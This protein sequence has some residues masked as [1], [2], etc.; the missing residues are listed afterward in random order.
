[1]VGI[2]RA[3]VFGLGLLL[4]LTAEAAAQTTTVFPREVVRPEV[5]DFDRPEAGPA[6]AVP[7]EEE[8][9]VASGPSFVLDGVR[10]TGAS[11]YDE[12]ELQAVA[13]PWIGQPAQFS[14]LRALADAVEA[15]YRQDGYLATRAIIAAQE[16]E[17]GVLD[18]RIVEGVIEAIALRGELGRAEPKVRDL[19]APLVGLKPLRWTE[20]ERRLLLAR[21]LPG[22]SLLASLRAAG[23][24]TEGGLVL[25]VD[26]GHDPWDAFLSA[27]NYSAE[28][29]GEWIV[30]GGAAA[31]SLLL[32]GDRLE[33][34][35]LVTPELGE[36][37]LALVT[38]E[39]PLF[40]DGLTFELSASATFSEPGGVLE[41]LDISYEAWTARAMAEYALLRTREWSAWVSAGL[42]ATWQDSGSD[43]GPGLDIDEE[44][45]VAFLGGRLVTREILG[46]VTDARIELRA[47]LDALGASEKGDAEL[48]PAGSDPQFQSARA[49]VRYD[50]L[51][52][53]D[54]SLTGK[55]AGQIGSE[56]LP[57]LELFSLG[58]YTIGRGFDPGAATGDSGVAGSLELGHR[59][60]LP[61]E[62]RVSE[63]EIFGFVEGGHVWRSGEED[64]LASVGLGARARLF[65]QVDVEATVAVPLADPEFSDDDDVRLLFR[66][67]SLF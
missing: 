8:A 61:F 63:P 46:G 66:A 5:P 59:I 50:R 35:G 28:T 49:N 25:V 16:I 12:A 17:G 15:R 57:S 44:L 34:I 55:V 19:L 29:A 22:V 48:S 10:F 32:P 3:L 47:G 58:N 14:D 21:D 39:A 33:G 7:V 26:A 64:G 62:E 24:G 27:S 6:L 53:P 67:L 9:P 65:D 30:T 43:V 11:V 45:R 56:D 13:A 51:L 54:L 20:A 38:Y 18:I 40:T 60:D 2:R 36:Q 52:T 42:D 31:N 41:P 1:M 4:I 37:E 23:T